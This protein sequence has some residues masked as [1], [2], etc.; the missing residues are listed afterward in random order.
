MNL[1]VTFIKTKGKS[2]FGKSESWTYYDLE[3]VE[4]LYEITEKIINKKK[5]LIKEGW[6]VETDM[7][8]E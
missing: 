5:R 2:E 4:Q 1:L 3:T 8:F 7:E 6:N